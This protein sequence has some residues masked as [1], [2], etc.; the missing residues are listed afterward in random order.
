MAKTLFKDV[1]DLRKVMPQFHSS[2]SAADIM[3]YLEDGSIEYIYPF[4]GEDF[5]DEIREALIA[6][7]YD[8]DAL[9]AEE[10]AVTNHLRKAEAFYGLHKGL[11]FMLTENSSS[12]MHELQ[13]EGSSGPRQWVIK[14][15]LRASIQKSDLFLDKALAVMEADPDSYATWSESDEFTI[16]H[17]LLLSHADQFK[18]INNSR[19]TFVKLRDYIQ[20]AEDKYF[21]PAFGRALID[22]LIA[23]KKTAATFTAKELKLLDY[24]YAALSYFSL[25]LGGPN[26]RLDI[27]SNGIRVVSHNDGITGITPSDVTA[28]S[29][30]L[31]NMETNGKVYIGKAKKYL[32]DNADDFD[33]YS[34]EAKAKDEPNTYAENTISGTKGSVMI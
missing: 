5:Y 2:G 10:Q 23:K 24:L 14:D 25:F 31:I 18:G 27:S 13:L 28:Y 19:R 34:A 6:A 26:L 1:A 3:P 22:A 15:Q 11:P 4:I 9:T 33:Y 17:E 8:L 7:D 29:N 16:H 32:D 30:W 20:L 12:G 21:E